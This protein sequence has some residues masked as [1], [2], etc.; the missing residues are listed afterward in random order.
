MLF[1]NWFEFLFFDTPWNLGGVGK[2]IRKYHNR[3]VMDQ[4][5]GIAEQNFK[6]EYNFENVIRYL[7]RS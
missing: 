6:I 1:G 4:E 2:E 3:G 5:H 7:K